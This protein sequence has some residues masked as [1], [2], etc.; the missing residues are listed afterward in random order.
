MANFAALHFI[1]TIWGICTSNIAYSASSVPAIEILK[2][3]IADSGAI[4]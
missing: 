4:S 1:G 2:P 3:P